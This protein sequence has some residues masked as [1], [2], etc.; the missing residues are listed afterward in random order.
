MRRLGRVCV[1]WLT[2]SVSMAEGGEAEKLWQ[3][4]SQQWLE[5]TEWL[6]QLPDGSW[7]LLGER[8]DQ[9]AHQQGQAWILQ[10]LALQERLGSV[11]MEMF[12]ADQQSQLDD[13]QAIGAALT[14]AEL[15]VLENGW[16]W[17][18]YQPQIN[19]VL[20]QGGRLLSGE[21][22]V[23]ERRQAAAQGAPQGLHSHAHSRQLAEMIVDAHCGL[24]TAARAWPM[25][26]VQLARDQFMA[27]QMQAHTDPQRINVLI[28]G[29]AHVRR[30]LGVPLWLPSS[31][32]HQVLIFTAR[33][34]EQALDTELHREW[35]DDAPAHLLWFTQAQPSRDYCAELLQ[36]HRPSR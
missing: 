9:D 27:Q 30:D 4:Q 6:G 25:V 18:R 3:V 23:A 31:L 12:S 32:A 2:L 5:S 28:A 11:V 16:E 26:E 29:S 8:H 36:R 35:Q 14:L 1:L 22:S 33:E 24:F 21:L 7:L 10:Q 20:K 19:I 34:D 15:E 13:W 17:S